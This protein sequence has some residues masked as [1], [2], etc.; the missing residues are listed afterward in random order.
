M[1]ALPTVR[2]ISLATQGSLA[3]V[4]EGADGVTSTAAAAAPPSTTDREARAPVLDRLRRTVAR[5]R[6]TSFS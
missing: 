1:T 5:M 6:F 4:A 3:A 2:A